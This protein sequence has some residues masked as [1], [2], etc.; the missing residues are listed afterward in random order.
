V[1]RAIAAGVSLGFGKG[2]VD[3]E[4]ASGP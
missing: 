1:G 2:A 4:A 3:P